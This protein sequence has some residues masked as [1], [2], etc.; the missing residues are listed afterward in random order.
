LT[1]DK[2][3]LERKEMSDKLFS[4]KRRKRRRVFTDD[5]EH[6]G[7]SSN[8]L[9]DGVDMNDPYFAEEFADGKYDL[10]KAGKK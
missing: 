7:W 9:P 6:D 3:D 5:G 1:W 2:T 4:S 8:D 10:P